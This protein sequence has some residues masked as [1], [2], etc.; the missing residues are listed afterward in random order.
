MIQVALREQDLTKTNRKPFQNHQ[1]ITFLL[2]K[3][4]TVKFEFDRRLEHMFSYQGM[5]SGLPMFLV[6]E[7]GAFEIFMQNGLFGKA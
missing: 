7:L 2:F 4:F 5:Q 6:G 1:S 3:T